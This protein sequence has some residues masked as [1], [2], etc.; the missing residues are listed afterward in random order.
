ML[1]L[2][3]NSTRR[4]LRPARLLRFERLE[5]RCVLSARVADPFWAAIDP[6]SE[7]D[8]YL[9]PETASVIEQP[10][11]NRPV[12]TD[13]GVQQMPSIAVNPLDSEH[14]VIA[15][16]DYSLPTADSGLAGEGYAGIGVAVSQDGGGNWQHTSIPLPEDFDQ[17]AANPIA[18]FDDQGRVYVS[19]MA[20]TYLGEQPPL[21]NPDFFNPDRNASDREF[22]FQANNGVFVA[23][24]DDGGLSWKGP[25]AVVSHLYETEEVFFDLIPDLAID[26]FSTL[27]DGQANPHYGNVYVTWTRLYAAGEMPGAPE[28]T[29]GGELMIA[30]S[31]DGGLSWETQLQEKEFWNDANGD[32]IRQDDEVTVVAIGVFDF[33]F[34]EFSGLSPG[35]S[36][37]DQDRVT[38]GPEGDVYV[39]AFGAGTFSV[40]HSTDGGASFIGPDFADD[41]RL[42]F[43]GGFD[44]LVNSDGL[45]GNRFRT[46]TVR[47]IAADP[48]RP[49]HVYAVEPIPIYDPLGSQL[50]GADVFFARS[51]DYGETWERTFLVG[52]NATD[53]L[54]DDNGGESATDFREDVVI[55]GQA[56]PRLTVDALGNIG[57]IWY[58]T[59][60]DP[61]DHLLDVFGTVSTDG[62]QNFSPNF[63]ITDVS[64]DADEGSFTNA[65]D[66]QEFYLGDFIGLAMTNTGRMP[67]GRT[68]GTATRMSSSPRVRL[69]RLPHRSMIG[70]SPT[71]LLARRQIWAV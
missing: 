48:T 18:K 17:G 33:F 46:H 54:N 26:M 57:V 68:L 12:T 30:V 14:L 63:R 42:A 43:G 29:G 6:P 9:A 16:M 3:P 7:P 55:A 4:K 52:L 41:R 71:R 10:I 37:V 59:R 8:T 28:N 60:R 45:P 2:S 49:G 22:G 70:L 69:I 21:T 27:P 13:A 62:G 15:Y 24:S 56:L 36:Y 25:V 35:I 23:R 64:F 40:H 20:V 31:R 58:D 47:A 67:R 38:I 44:T 39:S 66:E 53:I 65:T 50:D 61:A 5:S 1:R 11:V 51:T 32:G 34:R 19:F